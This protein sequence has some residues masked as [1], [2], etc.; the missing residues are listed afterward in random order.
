KGGKKSGD[1][2][3]PGQPD[4]EN[5]RD[6]RQQRS[7]PELHRN[8]RTDPRQPGRRRRV[9]TPQQPLAVTPP[10]AYN[11]QRARQQIKDEGALPI[12]P[13][14]SNASRKAHCPKRFYRQRHK[15]RKFLLSYQRL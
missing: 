3:Q 15:N 6:R 1:R 4:D 14:R 13:S 2:Y 12:I 10:K 9:D 7:A 8:R 5:P 11:S